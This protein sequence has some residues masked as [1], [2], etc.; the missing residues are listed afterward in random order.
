MNSIQGERPA[1]YFEGI[2]QAP[3]NPLKEAREELCGCASWSQHDVRM[4]WTGWVSPPLTSTTL[5]RIMVPHSQLS[6]SIFW[7][8]ASG[9]TL[10]FH[11]YHLPLSSLQAMLKYLSLLKYLVLVHVSLAFYR[12][13]CY[14]IAS[15]TSNPTCSS[16]FSLNMGS[17]RGFSLN[18]ILMPLCSPSILFMLLL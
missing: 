4:Q 18:L 1:L 11:T 10:Y 5:F 16:K 14:L 13:Q 8:L 15:L 12:L 9:F 2:P 3:W 6:F 17:S 7:D